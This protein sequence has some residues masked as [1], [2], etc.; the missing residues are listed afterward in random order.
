MIYHSYRG[1]NEVC[2]DT[3]YVLAVQKYYGEYAYAKS[4]QQCKIKFFVVL[5]IGQHLLLV[6][7]YLMI[8]PHSSKM[9][10]AHRHS[11][12]YLTDSHNVTTYL[13][14]DISVLL[15]TSKHQIKEN[16]FDTHR[17]DEK[18]EKKSVSFRFALS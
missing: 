7:S 11:F 17:R 6:T 12:C 5:N 15:T 1:N 4:T 8:D 10:S 16:M 2:A 13:S 18:K 3:R 9:K 14:S